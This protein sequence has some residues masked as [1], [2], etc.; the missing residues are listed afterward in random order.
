MCIHLADYKV[1]YF[2]V[3]KCA[4]TSLK[5]MFF[6]VENGFEWRKFK[7]N[8]KDFW[9]HNAYPTLE[10]E[11]ARRNAPNENWK[12]A[13]LRN[14]MDRLVSCY[15]NR[16]MRG[17]GQKQ[18]QSRSPELVAKGLNTKPDF[19]TF[20]A[21]YDTFCAL[22]S[23]IK[24]HSRPLSYFLG[25]DPSYYDRLFRLSELKELMTELGHRI[26]NLPQLMHLQTRG[27][28]TWVGEITDGTR[29]RIRELFDEDYKLFGAHF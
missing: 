8:G 6:E 21:E 1:S 15:R 26:T 16:V 20:V 14:P 22:S 3:P 5:T 18:L 19:G 10:F 11:A 13:V 12:F 2:A 23:D 9:V 24:G 25:R 7:A 29:N 17:R 28:E 4:C 27:A